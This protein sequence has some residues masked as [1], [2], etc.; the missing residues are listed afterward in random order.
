[1]VSLPKLNYKEKTEFWLD[2]AKNVLNKENS[3]FARNVIFFNENHS[4]KNMKNITQ[5]QEDTI[6]NKIESFSLLL[7]S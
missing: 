5:N 2:L 3:S 4:N 6:E 1:M 7:I